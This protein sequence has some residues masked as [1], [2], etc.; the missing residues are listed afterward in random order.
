MSSAN[1]GTVLMPLGLFMT[2]APEDYR[3]VVLWNGPHR[4]LSGVSSLLDSVFAFRQE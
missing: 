1:R 2:L 3:S 4:G